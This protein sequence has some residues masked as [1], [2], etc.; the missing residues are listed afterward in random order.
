MSDG[1][2]FLDRLPAR[3]FLRRVVHHVLKLRQFLRPGQ[4]FYVP[5]QPRPVVL[6]AP[7]AARFA[8]ED[9]GDFAQR[10]P[11]EQF[12]RLAGFDPCADQRRP[13]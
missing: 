12:V 1:D 4:G 9:D 13:V 3:P 7:H 8:F 2:L 11:P 6:A 10:E 5:C